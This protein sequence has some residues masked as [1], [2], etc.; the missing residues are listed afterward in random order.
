MA[1]STVLGF[2]PQGF[3]IPYRYAKTLPRAGFRGRLPAIEALFKQAEPSF[4]AWLDRLEPHRDTL[5]AFGRKP[6]PE[7]RWN[8]MWFPRLD[9]AMA[10]ALVREAK[11]ARIVEIGGGHSTRFMARSLKDSGHACR[12]VVIDPS[13]RAKLKGLDVEH[14]D[15]PL[16]QAGMDPF[17]LLQAGDV[18]FVDSSHILMPGSDVDVLLNHFL[19]SLPRGVLVHFHDIFLP[20]DYPVGWAWRGYNEQQ[21]VAALLHGGAFRPVFSSRYVITRMPAR[22]AQSAAAKLPFEPGSFEASLWLLRER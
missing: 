20:D 9:G 2:D 22:F 12:H 6:P 15:K 11:P 21:G 10:Y 8:Q 13:P 5:A 4:A 14:I 17:T 18:L 19:P 1:L 16:A 7:P 3:F